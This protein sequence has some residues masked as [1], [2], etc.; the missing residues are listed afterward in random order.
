MPQVSSPFKT[1]E[2]RALYQEWNARLKGEGLGE[3]P[4][5]AREFTF[6]R[7]AEMTRHKISHMQIPN[8]RKYAQA[9]DEVLHSFP[10]KNEVHRKIWELHC[11][12]LSVRKISQAVG[13]GELGKSTVNDIIVRIEKASGLKRE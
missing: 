12:G 1:P 9:A 13:V 6:R 5:R 2:F 11:E 7:I 10:F 4:V 8:I 3:E